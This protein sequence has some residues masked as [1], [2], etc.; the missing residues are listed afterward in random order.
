MIALAA[1][2][3]MQASPAEPVCIRRAD[4]PAGLEA[5]AKPAAAPAALKPGTAYQLALKDAAIVRMA[6]APTRPAAAGTFIAAPSLEVKTAGTYRVALSAPAWLDLFRDGKPLESVAH[7]HGPACSGI[8][9]IVDFDL[10]PGRY[11]LMVSGA[12]EPGATVL[13]VKK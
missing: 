5:W 11:T 8:R 7:T 3:L 9:K 10:K 12:K 2:A 6:V 13:V 4:P 1:L